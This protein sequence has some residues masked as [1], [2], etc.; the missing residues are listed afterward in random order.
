MDGAGHGKNP[1]PPDLDRESGHFAHLISM[2][3]S[4][5]HL[6]TSMCKIPKFT[7]QFPASPSG[8][9]CM[10]GSFFNTTPEVFGLS[11][12]RW[13]AWLPAFAWLFFAGAPGRLES[14]WLMLLESAPMGESDEFE[15]E[16][17]D[18]PYPPI[19]LGHFR[20]SSKHNHPRSS[21]M[22][23]I[24]N[25]SI[26]SSLIDLLELQPTVSEHH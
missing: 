23:D 25:M 19:Y 21:S 16:G 12:W 2:N 14:S 26:M 3:V 13:F 7:F 18:L 11:P 24:N 1:W 20:T 6:E 4:V 10:S 17:I 9:L 15:V 22:S 5:E 8:S